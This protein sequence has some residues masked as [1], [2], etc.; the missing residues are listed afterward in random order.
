MELKTYSRKA[1]KARTDGSPYRMRRKYGGNDSQKM[2]AGKSAVVLI[3]MTKTGFDGIATQN[4]GRA[5]R[6]N[7]ASQLRQQIRSTPGGLDFTPSI[8]NIPKMRCRQGGAQRKAVGMKG[9]TGRGRAA[10]V[11]K[12]RTRRSQRD[13]K[14]N[15]PR[16]CWI[17]STRSSSS[18]RRRE[19]G[20]ESEAFQH[21]FVS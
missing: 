19:R 12:R 5:S 21:V 9:A 10:V 14:R 18:R 2:K 1:R 15:F 20:Q 3:I 8:R 4:G 16:T 7:D 6:K 11:Q 13:P 17:Y